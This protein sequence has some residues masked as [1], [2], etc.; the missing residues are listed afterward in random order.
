MVNV[1]IA[2]GTGGVGRS[3]VDAL[4]AYGKHK[5]IILARKIP[6]VAELAF[7]VIAVDY[8][9]IDALRTV[10]EE[11]HIDTVISALALHIIGVGKS[12]INLIKASE[13]AIFTKRFV[14]STWA[15]R[16]Y[17]AMLPHGFQHIESYAEIEKTALEWTAFNLG[18]F[19]EYY[20]MPH[21]HTYIPQTSFVVDMANKHASIPGNG[22]QVMTFTYSKDVAKFVVAALDL[23]K[24]ERDTYVIGDKMTWEEFVKVA[25]EARGEKFTVVYD[26]VE[27]LKAGDITELPGQVAAYSYF[28]KEWTQKLFSVF[29]L[30]VTEGVFEFPDHKALN[31]QFPDIKVTTVKEMLDKA[32]RGK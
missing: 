8:D 17:L 5:V 9:D 30:W 32:W 26:S 12:Q 22:K 7:P 23:P 25:E 13:K 11:H 28:P 20:A 16:P 1:A 29:G 24:W 19:L 4:K 6:D 2:G 10:L 27:K 3:I 15:V 14:T 31:H 18:W 21:A